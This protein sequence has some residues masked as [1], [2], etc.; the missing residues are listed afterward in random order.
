MYDHSPRRWLKEKKK[1]N[2][3]TMERYDNQQRHR[4]IVGSMELVQQVCSGNKCGDD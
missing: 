2:P 1:T 4:K 3:E